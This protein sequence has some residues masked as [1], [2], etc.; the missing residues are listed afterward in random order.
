M[1]DIPEHTIQVWTLD[2]C[3]HE[4]ICPHVNT[5]TNKSKSKY[6]KSHN[7]ILTWP[8]ILLTLPLQ[9]HL[10]AQSQVFEPVPA[11]YTVTANG[12]QASPIKQMHHGA[13]GLQRTSQKLAAVKHCSTSLPAPYNTHSG[14]IKNINVFHKGQQSGTTGGSWEACPAGKHDQDLPTELP[15]PWPEVMG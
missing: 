12:L 9:H 4:H 14:K 11:Q 13:C 7:V 1:G 3:T 5:H 6:T 15:V 10:S 2:Y 8:P